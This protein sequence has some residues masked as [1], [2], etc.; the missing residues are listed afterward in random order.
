MTSAAATADKRKSRE[1]A[2]AKATMGSELWRLNNLYWVQDENGARVPF[3]QREPQREYYDNRWYLDIIAKGRQIGFCLDPS[4]RVLT[5][6]LR[7]VTLDD[8]SVGAGLVAV[9]EHPSAD[10]R[11]TNGRSLSRKMLAATVEKKW[12][13]FEEAVEITL[14]TGTKI[15]A[16]EP[17]KFLSRRLSVGVQPMWRRTDMLR[18][19]D[20]F[21]AIT[22]VWEG[23]QLEDAWF[24]GLLDGEGN[25]Q[26][27]AAGGLALTMT[28]VSGPVLDR[29]RDHLKRKHMLFREDIDSRPVGSPK[30]GKRPVHKLVVHRWGDIMRLLGQG[31]PTRF[32]REV[33]W[34]GLRLPNRD[35]WVQVVALRRVGRRRMI[36]IQ[37]SAKT[38]IAEGYV[39][40]NST[41]IG[42]EMLDS[43][44]IRSNTAAGIIDYKLED[45]KKKLA[46]IRF[47]Y[48]NL[49]TSILQKVR[50][51][52]DN[53]DEIHFTNGS[54]IEVG[55]SHRGG[56][57]Q[58][59]HVSE[60]GKIAVEKPETAIEIK[61]GAFQTIAAG[62]RIVVESTCH[63]TA[64]EFR[65][66]VVE[67]QKRE[68]AGLP[69]SKLD[70]RLHFIAW[71]RKREYR[72]P[73]NQV[74]VSLELHDYFKKLRQQGVRLDANQ[75]AWYARKF[76]DLGPDKMREEYPSTVE[77][78]FFASVEGAYFKRELS[79]ARAD[80]RIGREVPHDPTRG[81]YT[82]LDIGVDGGMFLGFGQTDGVRH[83]MIDCLEDEDHTG[84]IQLYITWLRQKETERGFRYTKHYAPH[85]MAQRDYSS[86]AKTR[87]TIAKELGDITVDVVPRILDKADSIET[88]RRFIANT[89]FDEVHCKR[90]VDCLDNYQKKWNKATQQWSAEP[91]KNG[92]DHGADSYQNAACGWSPDPADRPKSGRSRSRPKGATSWS[93]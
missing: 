15:V 23:A 42:L 52:K 84:S 38:F 87:A 67:T 2:K 36:D 11:A 39:S 32:D 91:L 20:E 28:Q 45:A 88:A 17:H 14:A 13:V 37:T 16:T 57:L 92:Y 34:Q 72:L 30:F 5:A 55:V 78:L 80:G 3:I 79:R 60:F 71:W 48:E 82:F 29:A 54:R 75:E 21:R 62:Q 41:E 77:E 33:W 4:T 53:E 43:C 73:S 12:D 25:F 49:P 56:T 66:M 61:T 40:H 44:I 24:A 9:D 74:V 63:G 1:Y 70:W 69:M 76:A 8:L 10:K 93:G 86:E 6:D 85:D 26:R 65:N 35:A 19:G 7:W 31:R 18:V 89:W 81:V 64:G 59:L 46:K 51:A 83:R 47:A 50:L 90:L 58:F 68:E 22:D 27:K